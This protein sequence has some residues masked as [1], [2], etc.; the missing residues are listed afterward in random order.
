MQFNLT[1]PKYQDPLFRKAVCYAIDRE[2]LCNDIYKGFAT[3][4]YTDFFEDLLD[5]SAEVYRFDMD[6]A[7]S[8]LSQSNWDPD[9]TVKFLR[10]T[11]SGAPNPTAEAEMLAYQEWF[12]D[13]GVNFEFDTKPDGASYTA[14]INDMEFDLFEN[15]HRPYHI[16]GPLE[17]QNYLYS[18]EGV[19]FIGYNN[20]D[21]DALI[22][23]AFITYG[24]NYERYVEIGREMSIIVQDE[25]VYVPTKAL[26]AANVIH[27]DFTGLTSISEA[28]LT[29]AQPWLWD[30]K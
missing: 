30:L 10:T 15:P 25:A 1:K 8:L 6:H 9:D 13:L 5:P 19:G 16:Y 11:P 17:M 2:T 27:N 22:E 28:Y 4:L 18:A 26:M 20:P 21:V 24:T 7:R 3:P 29:Y 12:T 14:A 23:E